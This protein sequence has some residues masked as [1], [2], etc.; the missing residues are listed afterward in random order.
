MAT[1]KIKKDDMVQVVNKLSIQ[2]QLR[3]HLTLQ[4]CHNRAVAEEVG[5]MAGGS[6]HEVKFKHSIT[7]AESVAQR[8]V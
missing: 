2:L 7:E 6:V 5:L 8:D 4:V 1:M 3:Q